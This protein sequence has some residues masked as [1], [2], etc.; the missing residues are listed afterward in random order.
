MAHSKR[1]IS[2]FAGARLK[3]DLIEGILRGRK[4]PWVNSFIKLHCYS[5]KG[6]ERS[7]PHTRPRP[8]GV[9][10]SEREVAN[11]AGMGLTEALIKGIRR[12]P[13]KVVGLSP[14]LNFAVI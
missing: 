7:A 6:F 10:H 12:G 9:A 11:F 4:V 1:E 3:K 13:L 8:I 2:N 5:T 14:L